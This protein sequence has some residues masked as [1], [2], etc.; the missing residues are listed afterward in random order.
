MQSAF[1][2]SLPHGR[3]G[4]LRHAIG[5]MWDTRYRKWQ[6]VLRSVQY[7]CNSRAGNAKRWAFSCVFLKFKASALAIANLVPQ[8]VAMKL[9]TLALAA[10]GVGVAGP[11]PNE[12]S[13][14]AHGNHRHP[15]LQTTTTTATATV[16]RRN[17]GG[18]T[19]FGGGARILVAID[20][21]LSVLFAWFLPSV[22]GC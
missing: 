22:W 6:K 17:C 2:L 5:G 20:R 1:L 3:S 12:A 21:V 11:F 14:C 8:L 13:F 9:L 4:E 7:E 15:P 18:R 16:C 19:S 10:L